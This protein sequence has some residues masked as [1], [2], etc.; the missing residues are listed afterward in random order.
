VTDRSQPFAVRPLCGDEL[1]AYFALEVAASAGYVRTHGWD[2]GGL[3]TALRWRR[4]VEGFERFDPSW[5]RGAFERQT[6]LGGYMQDERWLLL[7]GAPV[8]S[9]YVG[10]VVTHPHHRRRGV[11]SVLM[12][13]SLRYGRARGQAVLF[14]R[15]IPAFYGRFGYADV[16]EATEHSVDRAAVLA[17]PASTYTVRPATIE[18]APALLAL[19]ER[20]YATRSGAYA[21]TLAGQLH[22]LG[23]RLPEHPPILAIG[24]S[25]AV[26]GYAL[27]PAGPDRSL[28]VEVAAEDWPATLALLQYQARR[29]ED[30][31][32]V[33]A[34]L[35]WPMP[36][37][38]RAYYELAAHL[39][40]TSRTVSRPDAGAMAC[41]L[42]LAALARAMESVWNERW[43]RARSDW[44]G[45][46][47]LAVGDARASTAPQHCNL[48]IGAAGVTVAASH[49]ATATARLTPQALVQLAFGYRPI[50]WLADQPGQ[51]V[52]ADVR[53]ILGALFPLGQP[54]YPASDRC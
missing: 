35:R 19:Y 6:L 40:V 44:S 15:G 26:R 11:A 7:G 17:L 13:D 22:L 4:F 14:L 18:D 29:V 42:D 47:A 48:D 16:M 53:P 8:L 12:R 43:H 24:P 37:D 41:L 2:P 10:G 3:G 25:G 28:A 39:C 20:H 38:S 21:R 33:P 34:E 9:G 46:L 45:V 32:H 23:S 31:V 49:R 51:S 50:E 54:W 5:I 27:L 52:P 1:D 30:D 36:A